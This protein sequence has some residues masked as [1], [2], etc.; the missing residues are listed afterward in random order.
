[1]VQCKY[2]QVVFI[3]YVD[4]DASIKKEFELINAFRSPQ[5]EKIK[6]R[7]DDIVNEDKNHMK[8]ALE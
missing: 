5:F 2:H 6:N 3:T 1:M 8:Y 7:V 4:T